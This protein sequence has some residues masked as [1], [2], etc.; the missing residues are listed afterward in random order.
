M[1]NIKGGGASIVLLHYISN[2]K[3]SGEKYRQWKW[4]NAE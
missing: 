1:E 4:Y 2:E 3:Y